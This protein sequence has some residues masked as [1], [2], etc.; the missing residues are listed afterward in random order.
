M[1]ELQDILRVIMIL[2]A[3]FVVIPT[4]IVLYVKMGTYA[5]Y[6]T[7]A[8]FRKREKNGNGPNTTKS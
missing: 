8:R 2:L 3:L 5:F 1:I 7:Q 6:K 4:L